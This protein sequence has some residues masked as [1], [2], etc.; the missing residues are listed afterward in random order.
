VWN[1]PVGFISG[2]Q[3]VHVFVLSYSGIV[4][5]TLFAKLTWSHLFFHPRVN[6]SE[7]PPRPIPAW[8]SYFP[9][10]DARGARAF[11]GNT[12]ASSKSSIN[13]LSAAASRR[14]SLSDCYHY[15]TQ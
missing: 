5:A 14:I 7:G 6:R 4:A 8:L 13:R 3:Q 11:A 1:Q 12:A 15:V 2:S 10:R 9:C